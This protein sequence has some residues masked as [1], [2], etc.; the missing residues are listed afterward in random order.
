VPATP[1]H[2]LDFCEEKIGQPP[3]DRQNSERSSAMWARSEPSAAKP[4]ALCQRKS[5]IANCSKNPPMVKNLQSCLNVLNV[6]SLTRC[7]LTLVNALQVKRSFF[8]TAN[9]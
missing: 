4:M 8:R 6:V 3:M 2:E 1:A 9:L 5:T 7:S